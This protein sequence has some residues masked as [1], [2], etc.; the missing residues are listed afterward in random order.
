MLYRQQHEGQ[1]VQVAVV[2]AAVV[3]LH[4]PVL[5]ECLRDQVI[6]SIG[7][8]IGS[9]LGWHSAC[10]NDNGECYVWGWNSHGQLGVDF[11]ELNSAFGVKPI[12]LNI[13]NDFG[14]SVKFKKI[15]LGSNHSCLIDYENYLYSFGWNKYSQLFLDEEINKRWKPDS[16]KNFKEEEMREVESN[17]EID[18][19]SEEI[20]CLE[21]GDEP[22]KFTEFKVLDVKCGFWSTLVLKLE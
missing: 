9:G 4:E 6:L 3:V 13:F 1:R 10:L 16:K 14:K 5:I 17:D 22:E 19:E 15:S 21:Q 2:V 8:C 7:S 18:D 12:K 20:K 11:N